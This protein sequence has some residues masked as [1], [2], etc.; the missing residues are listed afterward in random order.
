M[1]FKLD[2]ETWDLV[3]T[4]GELATVT[5]G[6]EEMRQRVGVAL[7]THLGEWLYDTSRGVPYLQDILVKNPNLGAIQSR[8]HAYL[9][10]IEGVDSVLALVI[11]PPDENRSMTITVDVLTPF[12]VTGP[13]D[14]DLRG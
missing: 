9:L 3:I 13:F 6:L 14:V 5:D 10:T 7:R 4:G 2:P 11:N 1:D 8:L 12:G